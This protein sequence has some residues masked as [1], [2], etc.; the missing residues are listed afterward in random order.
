MSDPRR[1]LGD[2]R[3]QLKTLIRVAAV[4]FTLLLVILFFE[5]MRFIGR[6]F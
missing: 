1:L 4:G 5:L 6:L 2:T 3:G